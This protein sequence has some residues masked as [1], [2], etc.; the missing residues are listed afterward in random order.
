ML[1]VGLTVIGACGP[2]TA[3]IIK[4]VPS[5]KENGNGKYLSVREFDMFKVQ[6]MQELSEIKAGIRELDRHIK[7]L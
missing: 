1:G 5:R 7:A 2:I 4:F 6:Q 3:A